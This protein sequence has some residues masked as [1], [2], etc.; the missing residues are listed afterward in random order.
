M[1]LRKLTLLGLLFIILFLMTV[2]VGMAAEYGGAGKIIVARRPKSEVSAEMQVPDQNIG[3]RDGL[4]VP[5]DRM[6]PLTEQQRELRGKAKMAEAQSKVDTNVYKAAQGKYVELDREGEDPVWTVLGEFGDLKHNEIPEPDRAVD[7]TNIWATDFNR[8][9]YLDLLFAEDANSMR[10][11]YIENSSNRYAVH[12]DVTEWMPA[13]GDACSY[14]DT[15]GPQVWQF[16]I[17]TTTAWYDAQIAAGKSPA[18]IDE[19]LSDLRIPYI[20]ALR[21]AQEIQQVKICGLQIKGLVSSRL[22]FKKKHES[23]ADPFRS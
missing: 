13:P 16:M 4:A 5:D 1:K 8:A 11:F 22:F 23:R 3:A 2:S 10:E 6:D 18:E 9:Y 19:Y 7:N 12:G 14:D 21:D 20:G 17:D 15:T